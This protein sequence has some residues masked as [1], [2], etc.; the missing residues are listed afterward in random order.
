M[1][2]SSKENDYAV[3]ITRLTKNSS[4]EEPPG[5]PGRFKASHWPSHIGL[6]I[7]LSGVELSQPSTPLAIM[8]L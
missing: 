1:D 8:A 4:C 6:S 5:N 2:P 7:N 3:F